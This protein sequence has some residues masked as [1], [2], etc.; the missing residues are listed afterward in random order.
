MCICE[1]VCACECQCPHRFEESA[2]VPGAV[3]IGSWDHL[4]HM[5]GAEQG[6][7]SRAICVLSPWALPTGAED[8]KL[9]PPAR[10]ASALPTEPSLRSCLCLPT[11]KTFLSSQ[12]CEYFLFVPFGYHWNFWYLGLAISLHLSNAVV[13]VSPSISL[14]LKVILRLILPWG[15]GATFVFVSLS[16]KV[17]N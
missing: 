9:D 10:M 13:I 4:V 5:L 7:S 15:L 12:H 3:I 11:F 17:F 2:G 8:L 14:L 6:S 16:I 1:L